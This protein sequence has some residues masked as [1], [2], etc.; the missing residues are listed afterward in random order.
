MRTSTLTLAVTAA[1]GTLALAPAAA[2]TGADPS[3]IRSALA[4]TSPVVNVACWRYGWR[5]WGLYPGWFCDPLYAAPAY[6]APPVYDAPNYIPAPVYGPP[7]RCWI[8]GRWRAC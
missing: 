1:A 2:F 7:A 3:A 4:A 6:V 5:G 8:D